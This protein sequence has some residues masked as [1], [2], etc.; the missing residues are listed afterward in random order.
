MPL[1]SKAT[2]VFSVFSLGLVLGI[3]GAWSGCS[4]NPTPQSPSP[5]ASSEP[6]YSFA[7][8]FPTADTAQR[9]YDDADLNRAEQTYRGPATSQVVLVQ[10]LAGRNQ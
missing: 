5:Q 7:G 9:A 10:A 8:G 6:G 3:P 4:S 2:N 1:K